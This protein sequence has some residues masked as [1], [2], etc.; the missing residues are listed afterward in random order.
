MFV[1]IWQSKQVLKMVSMQGFMVGNQ[2]F[3]HSISLVLLMPKC[4]CLWAIG[5][6]L[7]LNDS[8]GMIL[9]TLRINPS[10]MYSSALRLKYGLRSG[11]ALVHLPACK[12]VA[13]FASTLSFAVSSLTLSSTTCML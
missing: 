6:I 12:A 11:S 1:A 3:R 2:Y 9:S 5:I 8:G 7:S 10:A 4:P 13:S